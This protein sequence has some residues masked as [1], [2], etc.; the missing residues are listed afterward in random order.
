MASEAWP[1]AA[2]RAARPVRI[3]RPRDVAGAADAVRTAVRDG[4]PVRPV[5]AGSTPTGLILTDGVVLDLTGL[6]R[7]RS[8]DAVARTV[9]VEAG[10]RLSRLW[11]WL[12]E[13]GLAVDSPGGLD[14][15]TLGG[16]IATGEHGSGPRFG[17]LASRVRAL[18]MVLAD[19]DVVHCT[20]GEH[21]D[22]FQ[23]AR[24]GLGAFG[25]VTAVTLAC[26]PARDVELSVVELESETFLDRVDEF[27]DRYDHVDASWSP[28]TDR[29]RCTT[30]ELLPRAGSGSPSGSPSGPPPGSPAGPR[31][32]PGAG[33]VGVPL[34]AA[35]ARHTGFTAHPGRRTLARAAEHAL[36]LPTVRRLADRGYRVFGRR[37]RLAGRESEYAVPR[38]CFPVVFEELRE[39]I[40]VRPIPTGTVRVRFG[41]AEDAWL[42]MG[43]GRET[44]YLCAAAPD[45]AAFEPF[46]DVLD[47]V[48]ARYD[49]RP[50]WG[51]PHGL[52]AGTLRGRYPRFDDAR[53]VRDRVDPR[54]VFRNPH[55]DRVLGR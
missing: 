53:A 18:E 6:D 29:V 46:F 30:A 34:G 24:V 9:V 38:A 16:A 25:V 50:H 44:T 49:G 4:L 41:A 51:R 13:H 42:A 28:E 22:L 47:V 15:Q 10:I 48:A 3:E 7:V 17:G 21:A 37:P 33:P 2:Y 23:A 20:E 1:D 11:P 39:R 55:L 36:G 5:G 14:H 32:E 43:Q 8:V 26:G 27:V 35:P 54:R 12:W 52:N 45:G 31:A 40:Q 19:G